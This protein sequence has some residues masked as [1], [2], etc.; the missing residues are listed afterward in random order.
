MFLHYVEA[1]PDQLRGAIERGAPAIIPLG[2]L[3]WHGPHLPLGLDGLLAEFC[4]TQLAEKLDGVLLPTQWRAMTTLPHEFSLQI[5]TETFRRVL[6]ETTAGLIGAGFK[7]ICY[8]SGHYAQGHMAELYLHARA[9]TE[10]EKAKVFAGSPLE[11]LGNPPLLDHAGKSETSQL[12]AIR[13]DLVHVDRVPKQVK[14]KEHGILGDHPSKATPE[15][16]HDLLTR[17]VSAW[18]EWVRMSDSTSL[19]FHYDKAIRS[20]QAYVDTYFKD[21]WEQAIIDWWEAK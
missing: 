11:L 18:V 8:I 13:P 14:A 2:A 20:Y 6:E 16:G 12:M 5:S 17:G 4:G 19:V 10:S 7:N 15:E 21:S 3:E 9:V 1:N